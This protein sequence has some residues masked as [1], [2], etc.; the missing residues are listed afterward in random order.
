MKQELIK[1][2]QKEIIPEIK[3]YQPSYSTKE[4]TK[5]VPN[6]LSNNYY[7]IGTLNRKNTFRISEKDCSD[8]NS[9]VR[10]SV[11]KINDLLNSQEFT[12]N[13]KTQKTTK[14]KDK[15]L[16]TNN[17]TFNINNFINVPNNKNESSTKKKSRY[18]DFDDEF[19]ITNN[20]NNNESIK[21]KSN[22]KR[23]N[24]ND[25]VKNRN[26][27]YGTNIH[28]SHNSNEKIFR[29]SVRRKKLFEEGIN[30]QFSNNVNNN[31]N[32]V[33][34]TKNHKNNKNKPKNEKENEKDKSITV[35]TKYKKY[36]SGG[37]NYSNSSR[38]SLNNSIKT[39]NKENQTNINNN[40]NMNNI[41]KYSISD[42][43]N[44]GNNI[45]QKKK[46]G[47]NIISINSLSDHRNIDNF[48]FNSTSLTNTT[49]NNNNIN[50]MNKNGLKENMNINPNINT[51]KQKAKKFINKKN[52]KSP[53]NINK[54]YKN[55]KNSFNED[56]K[57][58][59]YTEGKNNF[60][61][62]KNKSNKNIFQNSLSNKINEKNSLK[63]IHFDK[64]ILNNDLNE[65]SRATLDNKNLLK[66][67]TTYVGLN[68]KRKC[69]YSCDRR[70]INNYYHNYNSHCTNQNIHKI[71][72]KIYYKE[73][74]NKIKTNTIMKL[75]LFMNEYLISNNLLDD[76][77]DIT[78]QKKLDNYSKFISQQFNVDFPQQDDVNID[79]MVNGIKKI[80]RF[81][82]KK[83]ME[84]YMEK[85]NKKEEYELKK[86]V[87]NKYIKKA[88]F[89]IKK[90]LG[91]FNSMVECFDLIENDKELEEMFY[92]VQQV[93]K[94]KLTPYEKNVL[95]K[96][97][98]NNIIYEN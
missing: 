82:R 79:H 2:K 69:G 31:I 9:I 98:I 74:P 12:T 28:N 71:L 64:N 75:M 27:N 50:S 72:N 77:Y 41:L 92:N 55:I 32:I 20:M 51:N 44:N 34:Y 29:N 52:Y 18:D 14:D 87:L 21:I 48:L 94:K 57:G 35:N 90:I 70:N 1:D 68:L 93:I 96:E 8:I 54:N 17:F 49:N 73:F 38:I 80:Q 11:E 19:W 60:N 95:Y 26:I 91:L 15:P 13:K 88:G 42:D 58:L 40:T 4:I 5:E 86:M 37:T 97:Y 36:N 24:N 33:N 47:P 63:N 83:K 30:M 76:Y 43:V 6:S 85:N 56:Y 3:L 16:K 78:N 81:W 53:N 59:I 45:T 23:N 65:F 22:Q 67:E 25:K 39:K 7:N 62:N 89:K 66:K 84:K 46:F 10:N 61:L